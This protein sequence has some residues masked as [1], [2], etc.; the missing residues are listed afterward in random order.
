MFLE[1]EQICQLYHDVSTKF[2][3]CHFTPQLC[4]ACSLRTKRMCFLSSH[5]PKR[6][7]LFT[8]YT[9][10]CTH[11][12]TVLHTHAKKWC[13]QKM[14]LFWSQFLKCLCCWPVGA[15]LPTTANWP[16]LSNS[17]IADSQ[18]NYHRYTPSSALSLS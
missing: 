12:H 9:N 7:V 15:R 18:L 11:T 6:C 10:T 17:F 2:P 13:H 1:M 3:L 16:N 5:S 8:V 14:G 4:F